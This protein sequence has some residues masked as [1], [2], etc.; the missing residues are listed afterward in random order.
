MVS[1]SAT[2][3]NMLS[4][5]STWFQCGFN[6]VSTSAT[7]LHMLSGA[8]TCG[9]KGLNMWSRAQPTTPRVEPK[10]AQSPLNKLPCAHPRNSTPHWV[11]PALLETL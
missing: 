7:G 4:V 3:L 8:S 1:A 11:N 10:V 2:G 5:V 9:A 6:M